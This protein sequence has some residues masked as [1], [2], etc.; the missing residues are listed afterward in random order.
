MSKHLAESPGETN[1]T[2]LVLVLLERGVL[3]MVGRRR[4]VGV[5][6]GVMEGR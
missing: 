6:D 4:D 5:L 3:G 2:V 1:S